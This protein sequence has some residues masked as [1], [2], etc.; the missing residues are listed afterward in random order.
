MKGKVKDVFVYV[1][2]VCT[3]L[4]KMYIQQMIYL[5]INQKAMA[6]Y[7]E[8]CKSILTRNGIQYPSSI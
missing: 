5:G 3:F 2:Y 7:K 4:H 6:M 1:F 8:S